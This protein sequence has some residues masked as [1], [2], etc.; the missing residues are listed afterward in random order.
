MNEIVINKLQLGDK[1]IEINN[2]NF[3]TILNDYIQKIIELIT[4]NYNL[5]D[6]KDNIAGL[7]TEHLN[8]LNIKLKK[9]KNQICYEERCKGRKMDGSQCSRRCKLGKDF[10]GSHLRNLTYGSINDG[11]IFTVKEKGKRGRK[12]KNIDTPNSNFIE[13]WIDKDIG[14]GY[15]IDKNNL[16]YKNNPE[17]P[18]LI[19]I[20]VN[21]TIEYINEI[22]SIIFE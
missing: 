16:V 5:V 3:S 4:I 8:N 9:K 2:A 21:K 10:C 20:K 17:Y 15:L 7:V 6:E 22:P 13:T 11:Q 14:K 1:K 18:E 12:K 19:G